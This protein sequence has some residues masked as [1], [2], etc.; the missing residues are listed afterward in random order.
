MS[1]SKVIA[2]NNGDTNDNNKFQ[3]R[4]E[5]ERETTLFATH[6]YYESQSLG[7]IG[8][9]DI[10]FALFSG[11][12]L[13][14]TSASYQVATLPAHSFGPLRGSK[15]EKTGPSKADRWANLKQQFARLGRDSLQ[16]ENIEIDILNWLAQQNWLL[17]HYSCKLDVSFEESKKC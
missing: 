8:R 10:G 6:F 9:A 3:Y 14:W 11:P 13:H 1:M 4:E 17:S 12:W 16:W 2:Q 15:R 7:I 5:G